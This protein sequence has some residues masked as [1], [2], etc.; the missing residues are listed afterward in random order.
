M[1]SICC[2]KGLTLGTSRYSEPQSRYDGR[3]PL[4]A[5][6]VRLHPVAACA[7][8]S[9]V[10][11]PFGKRTPECTQELLGLEPHLPCAKAREVRPGGERLPQSASRNNPR[12]IASSFPSRRS[13]LPLPDHL[14]ISS[15][16]V[17]L[18]LRSA[19]SSSVSQPVGN[20]VGQRHRR[21]GEH[22]RKRH[23]EQGKPAPKLSSH[24]CLSSVRSIPRRP[25]VHPV[26]PLLE[27]LIFLL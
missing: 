5:F 9:E 11:H 13:Y 16:V 14:R 27:S 6:R 4:H 20:V 15:S 21:Y 2:G 22:Q 1:W 8:P 25:S 19:A 17:G 12:S 3:V 10:S 26:A 23:T 18:A 7:Q 24:I